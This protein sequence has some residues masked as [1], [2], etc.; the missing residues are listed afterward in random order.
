MSKKFIPID[1]LKHMRF[2][3]LKSLHEI[4][5]KYH[6][7]KN[8]IIQLIGKTPH[9]QHQRTARINK[10]I[11]EA[12]DKTN[13]ELADELGL[14]TTYISQ[15]RNEKRHAIN[16]GS[17]EVG[18]FWEDW[19]GNILVSQGFKVEMMPY[20]HP[21]DILVNDVVRIDTKSA[22][23]EFNPPSFHR[24]CVNKS[25]GCSWRFKIH[26]FYEDNCDIYACIIA[27]TKDIFII[28][29]F[30]LIEKQ[31]KSKQIILQWPYRNYS[32]YARFHN[33]F[34]L[35]RTVGNKFVS[36]NILEPFSESGIKLE[37]QD[38]KEV[39]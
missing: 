20:R 22:I 37:V 11:Q 12:I 30:A 29:K 33:N 28:P 10:Y 8:K 32:K 23:T 36:N 5:K 9:I 7:S 21:F 35:I 14:S 31:F 18:A 15:Q 17:A 24:K 4:A 6:I 16:G 13:Q 39:R 3:E 25:W 19:F 2:V 38:A 26:G 27:Q 1:D 34:D